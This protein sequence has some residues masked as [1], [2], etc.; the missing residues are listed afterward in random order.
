[1]TK[2][3]VGTF[4]PVNHIASVGTVQE[5][6]EFMRRHFEEFEKRSKLDFAHFYAA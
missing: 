3:L 6:D 4:D 2:D 1:L 5:Q